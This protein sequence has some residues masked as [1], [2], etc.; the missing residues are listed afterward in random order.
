MKYE[1]PLAEYLSVGGTVAINDFNYSG[2]SNFGYPQYTPYMQ[3]PAG[4][5]STPTE[6]IPEE[7]PTIDVAPVDVPPVEPPP[8]PQYETKKTGFRYQE[9]MAPII[10]PAVA[11][12]P[13]KVPEPIVETVPVSPVDDVPTVSWDPSML[14]PHY[15]PRTTAPYSVYGSQ[16][17]ITVGNPYINYTP[18]INLAEG[19]SVSPQSLVANLVGIDDESL[20]WAKAQDKRYPEETREDGTGDAARH[21]ALGYLASQSDTPNLALTAANMR[22]YL[23]LNK[24][25]REM[26]QFNNRLGATIPAGSFEEV[27]SAIDELIKSGKAKHMTKAESDKAYKQSY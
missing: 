12:E 10:T 20:N 5:P 17:P 9:G 2:Y 11:P 13:P 15:T 22:E 27:E 14:W 1:D 6:I 8:E 4:G 7:T 16:E 21:L 3:P 26:D 18:A 25:A 23:S 19:G 24:P